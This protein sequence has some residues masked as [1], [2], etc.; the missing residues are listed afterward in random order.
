MP[1][2]KQ[3]NVGEILDKAMQAFWTRGYEAPSM[4][5]LVD[6]TGVNRASLYA[7]YG[8]KRALFLAALHRYDENMRKALIAELQTESS[9][10]DAIR[11]LFEV[12]VEQ[13][14]TKKDRRGCFLTNTA[15]EL[16]THDVAIGR[17]VANAQSE[18]E[19]FFTRMIIKAK[20]LGDVSASLKPVPC[21]RGLLASLLGLVVLSRS[22]PDPVLLR[23]V[24]EDA[25]KR[26]D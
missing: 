20:E 25:M 8:D 17:I 23:T 4:Q 18:I 16:A 3:F 11:R 2:E 24:V 22:R 12:F 15:L 9:P 14:V 6:R 13:A 21:A 19:T 7:T 1:W 10:R 26:L 5:D